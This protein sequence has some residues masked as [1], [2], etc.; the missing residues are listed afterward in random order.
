VITPT[1]GNSPKLPPPAKFSLPGAVF[2][3]DG[4]PGAAKRVLHFDSSEGW[5][6]LF[7]KKPCHS[8]ESWNLIFCCCLYRCACASRYPLV[9]VLTV[10]STIISLITPTPGKWSVIT[11]STGKS[12]VPQKTLSFQRKLEP[13]FLL[14]LVRVR[15]CLA[16]PSGRCSHRTKHDHIID[17]T[18]HR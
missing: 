10:P 17:N 6:L 16:L 9:G 11:P 15:V 2:H 14:L 3:R 5:N 7:P 18:K 13:H 4:Q 1:T 12:P 8:S